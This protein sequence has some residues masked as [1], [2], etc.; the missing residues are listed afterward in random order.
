MWWRGGR[1]WP[2]CDVTRRKGQNNSTS[3]LFVTRT[4]AYSINVALLPLGLAYN[5]LTATVLCSMC[6]STQP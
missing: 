3:L 5:S 4:D 1:A 2:E 6:T